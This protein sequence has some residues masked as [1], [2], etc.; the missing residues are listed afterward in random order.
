MIDRFLAERG[1]GLSPLKTNVYHIEEGF[2]FLGVT[3]RK[4]QGKFLTTPS[5]ENVKGFLRDV[6]SCFKKGK[7]RSAETLIATLNPKI[8]GWANYYRGG[9]AKSTFNKV[10][11]AIY[12]ASMNWVRHQFSNRQ[13]YKAVRR[14]YREAG[15]RRW[16]F[17]TPITKK[18]GKTYIL[19][20]AKMMDVKIIRHIKIKMDSNPF[21]PAYRDYYECR[22]RWRRAIRVR[23]QIV[24]RKRGVNTQSALPLG[25]VTSF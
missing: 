20:L 12:H 1:V 17:S 15:G 10:D 8:R 23:Q 21:D 18:D 24:D 14:Y 25:S 7:G 22:Q 5:K 9:A 11:V 4:Y 3:V 6:R 19:C 13:R 16:I 2:E